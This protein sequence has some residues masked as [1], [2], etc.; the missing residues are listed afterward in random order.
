VIVPNCSRMLVEVT[1][2][3]EKFE[4]D[5]NSWYGSHGFID[6][7][8]GCDNNF[9]IFWAGDRWVTSGTEKTDVLFR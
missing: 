5:E 6:L 1:M 2:Q 8:F 4:G 3:S 7:A 9:C